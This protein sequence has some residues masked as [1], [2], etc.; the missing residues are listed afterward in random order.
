VLPRQLRVVLPRCQTI[1]PHESWLVRLSRCTLGCYSFRNNACRQR[2]RHL[3]VLFRIRASPGDANGLPGVSTLHVS[4]T[5]AS[6]YLSAMC[7][8]RRGPDRVQRSPR[9]ACLGVSVQPVD[10]LFLPGRRVETRVDS[11]ADSGQTEAVNVS[12]S[13]CYGSVCMCGAAA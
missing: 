3:G 1:D 8:D 2:R 12:M 13:P 9:G 11:V 4:G 6:V 5:S 10:P 7:C